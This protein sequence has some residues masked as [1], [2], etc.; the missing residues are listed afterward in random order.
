M[1]TINMSVERDDENGSS[2]EIELKITGTHNVYVP[3]RLH[4]HPDN[5]YPAEGGDT[6]IENV[7]VIT[8]LYK[9]LFEGLTDEETV[10][11][12]ELIQKADEDN[13]YEPEPEPDF[14]DIDY[15]EG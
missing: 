8:P 3:A 11:A 14:D 10:Q 12:E 7:E 2:Q 15:F 5:A 6:E 13:F 9:H 1:T 4:C